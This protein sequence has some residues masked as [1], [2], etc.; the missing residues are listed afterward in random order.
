MTTTQPSPTPEAIEQMAAAFQHSRTLLTAV[1]LGVFETLAERP[2][3]PAAVATRIKAD[4]R[5]TDRLLHALAA[6]GLLEKIHNQFANTAVANACLV[7]GRPGFLGTLAHQNRLYHAWAT[8]T[9]SVRAGTAVA[10]RPR[11]QAASEAFIAAMHHRAQNAAQIAAANLDLRHARRILDVGGGSGAFAMA[12]ARTRPD[13]TVTILDM[14]DITPITRRY[15]DAAGLSDRIV[16]EDGDFREAL[17]GHDFDLIFF[18]AIVHMNS[19]TENAALMAQ[20]ATVAA[21]GGQIVIRDFVMEP[22]R[23]HPPF[24][25]LFALN[26]LV[27]TAHGDTYTEAEIAAWLKHAGCATVSRVDLDGTTA[28]LIGRLPDAAGS[29]S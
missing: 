1:E 19:F 25:A 7:A 16:V 28:M 17:P 29:Q 13:I 20:A 4:A 27:N 18:S 5:A 2:L 22:D 14:P 26:M 3:N 15:V 9:E 24:G 23:V 21:P 10:G 6:M 12:F 8:L 11:D